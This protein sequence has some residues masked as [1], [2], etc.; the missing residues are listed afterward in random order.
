MRLAAAAVACL[1]VAPALATPPLPPPLPATE[2]SAEVDP[3]AHRLAATAS[4]TLPPAAEPSF[5]LSSKLVVEEVR[6]D[7]ERAA[8]D[9]VPVEGEKNVSRLVVH[10]AK[11]SAPERR[12]SFKYAGEIFAP[13]Q[14]AGFSREQIAD[15]TDGTIQPEG[16]FL[17]PEAAWYPRLADTLGTFRLEVRVPAGWDAVAEGKVTAHEPS[18]TGVRVA[19]AATQPTEGLHLV[20]G[21]WKRID[22]KAGA[23]RLASYVY[24]EDL[25]L[26]G[27]YI[28]ALGR[29]LDMY[30]QWF[31]PY[32]YDAFAVVENFF[33]T[34]YGMAGFTVLGKDVMKLPFI[35]DTSLGH[36]VAHSWWGNGVYVDYSGGN[37][38]E[39]L[40]SYVADHHYKR[41]QSEEAGAEYRRETCRDY[42][43]YVSQ[44]DKDFPLSQFTERTTMNTRAVG[45]G[46]TLM[47]FRMLEVRLGKQKFDAA[48]KRFY[49][50]QKFK[51][52][53]WKDLEAAFTKEAGE[54]LGWFFDQWVKKP[55]APS[56][57]LEGVRVSAAPGGK[58]VVNG[59]LVQSGGPWR[60]TVP[61][62]FE[63]GGTVASGQSVEVREARTTF[64]QE[65]AFKPDVLRADPH[66]DVFRK[67]DDAE[68]PPVLSR[69]LG[70]PK[71][72]FVVAD[73]GNEALTAAYR[74]LAETVTRSGMGE[75]A[76]T[77]K[78][79]AEA[80]AGRNVFFLGLPKDEALRA[81]IAP[82]S[83][84]I[85]IGD[86]GFA[87]D[88]ADHA[89]PGATLLSVGQRPGDTSHAVGVFYGFTPDGVAQAG[90]KLVHYG[91]YSYLAFVDGKNIAKG[92]AK[93]D[94]GP[95]VV[96][97]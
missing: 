83:K 10:G 82:P 38:C 88:G 53:S 15:E 93:M 50:E 20:A 54:D 58:F 73:T 64:T 19:F 16:V 75:I 3:V 81:L 40:T 37:W 39:G 36:E 63:H 28:L 2:I 60:L 12:Y 42:T 71:T 18:A 66:Q 23:I 4:I 13:P 95:L 7:G 80:L 62:A 56:L 27:K 96:R 41:L 76:A 87:V 59:T 14:V 55:G 29:Y 61:M 21:P 17:A 52:A 24:P 30:S 49:T 9:T 32:P 65:L 77:S 47:V 11:R 43:N 48:L 45:Y 34:G 85:R 57:A 72:L 84:D 31:G 6:V 90:R 92:V 44:A 74:T 94:G 97:F 68:I 26:G 89:E 79:D 25:E 91:K 67:L 86:Q 33:S 78:P 69:L 70:D 22:A 46:K 8:F 51:H 1:L 35:I 5:R